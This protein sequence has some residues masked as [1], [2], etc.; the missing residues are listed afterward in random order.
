MKTVTLL[1]K[2]DN[3]LKASGSISQWLQFRSSLQYRKQT[4]VMNIQYTISHTDSSA[5]V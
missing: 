4:G 1:T 2:L 5:G 3:F